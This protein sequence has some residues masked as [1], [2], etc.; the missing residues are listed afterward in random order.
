[1]QG[2]MAVLVL[3]QLVVQL[4]LLLPSPTTTAATN[5]SFTTANNAAAHQPP[6]T[7]D[8]VVYGATPA[9]V[10]AAVALARANLTVVVVEASNVTGGAMSGGL[11]TL[12]V[13]VYPDAM[14]GSAFEVFE[15]LATAYNVSLPLHPLPRGQCDPHTAQ[16]PWRWE[17]HVMENVLTDMLREQGPRITLLHDTRVLAVSHTSAV[18]TTLTALESTR[19][20]LAASVFLDCSYEG[21]LLYLLQAVVDV[22][23]GREP[24]AQYGERVG[25]VLPEP[26]PRGEPYGN[27]HQFAVPVSPYTDPAN[28]SKGC[29]PHVTTCP[30]TSPS[31]PSPLQP[32]AGDRK[33]GAYDWRVLLTS[34]PANMLPLPA[35]RSYDAGE[36][37]LLRRIIAAYNASGLAVPWYV[38][39]GGLPGAKTDWKIGGPPGFTGEYVGGSWAYPNASWAEQQALVEEHKQF[40]L[41]LLHFWRT[42]PAVPR[43]L[44]TALDGLGLARDEFN[45]TGHWMSQLYV[46]EALRLVGEYVMTEA[47]VLVNYTKPDTIAVGSYSVDIPG[48]VQRAAYGNVTWL[49]GGMQS[50]SLCSPAVPPFHIPLRS[51]L[52]RRSQCGNLLVPVALSA[53]H[54]AFNAIRMEPQWMVLGQSAG[55]AAAMAL[56]TA[57]PLHDLPIAAL[58]Q[59]LR[60]ARQVLDLSP[61]LLPGKEWYAWK[62]M[63]Q[64]AEPTR[65]VALQ[66][67]A[68]LKKSYE[69]SKN[70]PPPDRRFYPKGA[71][72]DL[73][74]R[75]ANASDPAY[76]LVKLL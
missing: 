7:F 58:Q 11:G 43:R 40:A 60:T 46:R 9:G 61:Q 15:R 57:T 54:V 75:P 65:L 19:G 51:I 20:P 47:D 72:L 70:L 23:Y 76:W 71:A 52:P 36:F 4:L 12:D 63:W 44:Q 26:T 22:T 48:A 74:A 18:P 39:S 73:A 17:A 59:R 31:L 68:V 62:A 50:P 38:P 25:G 34:D 37:E 66:D 32:G 30:A 14:G 1:M 56:Q 45:R 24:A 5:P 33:L 53:S 2:E 10:M 69:S 41:R 16:P 27:T 28:A 49:E 6:A 55:I 8:A 3:L 13:G 29:L 35:P 42:D 21:G 64:Q 67:Q